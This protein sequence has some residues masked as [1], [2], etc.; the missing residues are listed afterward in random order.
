MSAAANTIMYCGPKTMNHIK[1]HSRRQADQL[2]QE[3]EFSATNPEYDFEDPQR[4][5]LGHYIEEELLRQYEKGIASLAERASC[6]LMW[7]HYGD[8]HRGVCIGYSVPV[9]AAGELYKVK[10]GGSRLVEASKVAAMLAGDDIA[11]EHVNEAVLFRK[12]TSWGYEREW[13]LIGIR[14]LKHSP[15]ELEEIIFGMRCT[16]SVKYAVAKAL[17]GRDR[18]VKFYEMREVSGT[19]KLKKYALSNDDELFVHFPRRSLSISEPFEDLLTAA[20]STR[21]E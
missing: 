3:I 17:E 18:P 4:L 8:Q 6:P 10:Y 1:R 5:L 13:R 11:R 19:F 20:S 2:I 16:P 14:G 12:A 21:A 15:L 7:S 9:N